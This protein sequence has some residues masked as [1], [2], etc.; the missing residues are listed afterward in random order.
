MSQD[1]HFPR[2][3]KASTDFKGELSSLS[4][5]LKLHD[6]VIICVLAFF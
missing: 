2:Y 5:Y 6:A 1:G 3:P 4:Q